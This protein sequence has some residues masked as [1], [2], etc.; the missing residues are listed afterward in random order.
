MYWKKRSLTYKFLFALQFVS[1]DNPELVRAAVEVRQLRTDESKL[2]QENFQLQVNFESS[3]AADKS[4][5]LFDHLSGRNS[6][7][8]V[9]R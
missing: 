1:G 4:S 2:R 6:T 5:K 8:A 3:L 7:T 9:E